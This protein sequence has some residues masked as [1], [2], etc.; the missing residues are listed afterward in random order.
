MFTNRPK[1]MAVLLGAMT[2]VLFGLA[3]AGLFQ[4]A[5]WA[6]N[7]LRFFLAL[8]ILGQLAQGALAWVASRASLL[9]EAGVPHDATK[10]LYPKPIYPN[11]LVG[12]VALLLSLMLAAGGMVLGSL[13]F[14]ASSAIGIAA[15]DTIREA[16]RK[17][18]ERI[19]AREKRLAEDP[20]YRAAH[21]IA[22]SLV[23]SLREQ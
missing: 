9:E 1:Q 11:R 19:D 3:Y 10:I 16:A 6:S 13:L 8:W 15:R 5:A 18:N 14:L 4:G 2:P 7:L 21:H 17:R 12:I 22:R 20:A 23:R